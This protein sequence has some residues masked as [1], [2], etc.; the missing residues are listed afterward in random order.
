MVQVFTRNSSH[1]KFKTRG[2][3]LGTAMVCI[4]SAS[5][6]KCI[7]IYKRDYSRLK[8]WKLESMSYDIT[9]CTKC[10][11]PGRKVGQ[12]L[13][14]AMS[15]AS[16]IK[17]TESPFRVWTACTSNTGFASRLSGFSCWRK[18]IFSISWMENFWLLQC[19]RPCSMLHRHPLNSTQLHTAS[20]G[21]QQPLTLLLVSGMDHPPA[22]GCCLVFQI[23][24]S[25]AG[26]YWRLRHSTHTRLARL[27]VPWCAA[28]AASPAVHPV[29]ADAAGLW[30]NL[31]GLCWTWGNMMSRFCC[32]CCPSR[33]CWKWDSS[34]MSF[35]TFLMVLKNFFSYAGSSIS[36]VHNPRWKFESEGPREHK[37]MALRSIVLVEFGSIIEWNVQSTSSVKVLYASKLPCFAMPNPNHSKALSVETAGSAAMSL[38]ISAIRFENSI[39]RAA[40]PR[41]CACTRIQICIAPHVLGGNGS[42]TEIESNCPELWL[43]GVQV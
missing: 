17:F 13:P 10:I 20:L 31:W 12:G 6:S 5:S 34:S 30:L 33:W 8:W 14:C 3:F 38:K 27:L 15:M 37:E 40:Q 36:T 24:A 2:A 4:D 1:S 29:S 42:T 22:M 19:H 11:F 9:N 32:S 25:F 23:S 18:P 41:G 35:R 43:E 7:L 28:P 26:A 21:L 16:P 39:A